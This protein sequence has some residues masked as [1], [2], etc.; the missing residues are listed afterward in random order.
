MSTTRSFA[1]WLLQVTRTAACLVLALCADAAGQTSSAQPRPQPQLLVAAADLAAQLKDPQLL[2]LHVADRQ[3]AFEDEHIPGAR[4]V[5]YADIAVDGDGLGSELPPIDALARVLQDAGVSE[6]RTVVIYGTST[7][8]AA[9]LFFTLDVLGHPRLSLLDGGLRAWKADG[10]PTARG[11]AAPTPAAS[12]PPYAPRLQADRLA[13]A[14]AI[15]QRLTTSQINLVDVRPDAEFTGAD[16]G[17]RGV[18]VAGHIAGARQLPWDTLVDS[19]GRFLPAPAL[20]ARLDA[21]GIARD[22]PIVA[23]CMVGMRASVVYFIARYL[24]YDARLYD[25]SIVDWT[26]RGLPAVKGQ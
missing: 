16:G 13:D 5:R 15:Q 14:A 2:L 22:K 3:A 6:S 21:V 23:Y 17:M 19:T 26:R 8:M 1:A 7:V 12:A 25:G 20:R 18:H 24:G 9:R 11:P 4:F 10:R